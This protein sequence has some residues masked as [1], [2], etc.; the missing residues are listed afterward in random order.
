M[1]S[2]K[3]GEINI[4]LPHVARTLCE[5]AIILADEL[6]GDVP[7]KEFWEFCKRFSAGFGQ[8]FQ[9]IKTK[10]IPSYGF[11]PFQLS[12]FPIDLVDN[13]SKL[14]EIF[15]KYEK[16]TPFIKSLIDETHGGQDLQS[17]AMLILYVEIL[18]TLEAQT[19]K[20]KK[21]DYK[22]LMQRLSPHISNLHKIL[23]VLSAMPSQAEVFATNYKRKQ[24]ARKGG[25]AK[26]ARN[27]ELKELVLAEATARHQDSDATKAAQAIYKKLADQGDWLL[28]D[29]GKA[30]LK[31]PVVR[32]TA[33]IRE[34]R[35][36]KLH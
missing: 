31:D 12:T 6:R 3:L 33:W 25:A 36:K 15:S 30:I 27:L 22:A 5:D 26:A 11:D 20:A 21:I 8:I 35:S 23:V 10:G 29:S 13:E 7:D 16:S 1:N 18:Y 28:D 9:E 2:T 4:A 32:F 14:Q 24:G 19:I 34:A 17:A